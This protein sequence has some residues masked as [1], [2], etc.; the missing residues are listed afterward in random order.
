MGNKKIPKH[1]ILITASLKD[2]R[3]MSM[4]GKSQRRLYIEIKYKIVYSICL[5]KKN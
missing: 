3:W 4:L 2:K 5:F 1:R